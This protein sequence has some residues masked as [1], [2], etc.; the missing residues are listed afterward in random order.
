MVAERSGAN[1]TQN[2]RIPD[3]EIVFMLTNA[4]IGAV[5]PVTDL[6]RA[7]KFYEGVLGLP[8]LKEDLAMGSVFYSSAGTYLQIYQRP[9]ASSGE[10]TIAG[11]ELGDG[12]DA[13]VDDLIAHGITFD[14]FEIPG[15]NLPWDERGV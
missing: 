10:H 11:F 8:I 12:F 4:K 14:T 7:R 2:I 9:T 1:Y 13:A 3:K 6:D 5:I 15:V